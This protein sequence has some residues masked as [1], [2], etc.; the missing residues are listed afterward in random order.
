M[1]P[2]KAEKLFQLMKQYGV[3]HFQSGEVSIRIGPAPSIQH[4]NETP[5]ITH[6]TGIVKAPEPQAIPPVE[7][8]IPHH[9]NEVANLLRLNDNDLVD[10]LFPDYTKVQIVG[11]VK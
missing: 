5:D 9:M 7:M 11:E 10:K 8:K 3:E 2:E 4:K 6:D 1:K